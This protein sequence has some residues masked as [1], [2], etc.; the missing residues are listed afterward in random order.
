MGG[1]GKRSTWSLAPASLGY[2]VEIGC[3]KQG[4]KHVNRDRPMGSVACTIIVHTK[5]RI[6]LTTFS[7]KR[8]REITCSVSLETPSCLYCGG[9]YELPM[10]SVWD[11]V[12]PRESVLKNSCPR[13]MEYLPLLVAFQAKSSML[14]VR[15]TQVIVH[16]SLERFLHFNSW[17]CREAI[18]AP[19]YLGK[20]WQFSNQI[21]ES[22]KTTEGS[23]CSIKASHCEVASIC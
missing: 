18:P 19:G 12:P 13:Y 7:G 3:L 23:L 15:T 2:T 14:E 6:V 17:V 1:S 21:I 8:L 11:E 5:K 20:F 10:A 22:N 4:W 16:F 9:W